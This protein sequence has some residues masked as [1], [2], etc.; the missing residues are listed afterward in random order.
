MA[1]RS[2]G[3]MLSLSDENPTSTTSTIFTLISKGMMK[4]EAKIKENN[5]AL[6]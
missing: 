2:S 1:V 4:V 6:V 3:E 5:I